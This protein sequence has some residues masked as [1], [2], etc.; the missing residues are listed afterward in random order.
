MLGEN[1][2]RCLPFQVIASVMMERFGAVYS[3]PAVVNVE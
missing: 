1:I 2:G 3:E